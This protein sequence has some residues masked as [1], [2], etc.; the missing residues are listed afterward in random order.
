MAIG[1]DAE[2]GAETR[3]GIAAG[4][5]T[6]DAKQAQTASRVD[7]D[8]YHVGAYAT[9]GFGQGFL[10]AQLSYAHHDLD[11]SRTLF[12]G[13]SSRTATG[14][15]SANEIRGSIKLGANFGT[16]KVDFRPFARLGYARVR[17]GGL[18]ERGAGD[19]GLVV[20]KSRFEATTGSLGFELQGNLGADGR[21]HPY[22]DVAL[23]HDLDR[24]G[25]EVTNRL[26]GGGSAFRVTGTRPGRT[27]GIANL[28]VIGTLGSAQFRIGYGLEVRER[29]EAH[30]LSGGL[31]LRW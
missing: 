18:T 5:S 8:S 28:G 4:W 23:A 22:A 25:W 19:A 3:M 9:A 21:I 1:I 10:D 12:T 27:A 16:G 7:I 14:D 2:P 24:D 15:V 29:M 6:G 31:T 13:M 26:I 30:T 17:Q 11:V 20:G